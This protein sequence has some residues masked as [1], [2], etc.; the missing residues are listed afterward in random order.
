LDLDACPNPPHARHEDPPVTVAGSI[1][2]I[3]IGLILYIEVGAVGL[4][5]MI[6]G[7]LGVALSLLRQATWARRGRR[8]K[9][10]ADDRRDA[11]DSPG[12]H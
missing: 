4:I 1:F 5:L 12:P 10:L 11:D 6:V 7:I 9:P 2:L 3:V 8:P